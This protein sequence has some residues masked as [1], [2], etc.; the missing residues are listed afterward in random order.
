MLR[1]PRRLKHGEQATL[2]E[3][4]GELRGRLVVALVA[5]VAGFIVAYVFHSHLIHWLELK[6]PPDHRQL[7]TL[8]V[9]EP[10]LTAV[11]VSLYAGF[12]IALPVIIYELW[13]FFAPALDDHT[14]RAVVGLT[15]FATLLAAAGLTFAYLVA[16]PAALHF[17]TNYDDP[18][19]DNFIRARDFISF[20]SLVLLAV[21][22]VF[23]IPVVIL[24]LVRIG[25]LSYAKLKRNRRI[26]Y[27]LMA[28]LAVALPGVDPVTTTIEMIP[29]MIL[30]EGSIWLAYFSERRAR[31]R[32]LAT[33]EL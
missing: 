12:I 15:A 10:F 25:V 28:A 1:L 11:Q 27:V 23:E 4:L 3:H 18:L 9:A 33:G 14:Q 24:G 17:L 6:L 26:G 13:A 30:F 16:L 31:R 5:L 32:D 20:S 8:S 29:M 22:V 21:T 19:Y 7:V 2:V